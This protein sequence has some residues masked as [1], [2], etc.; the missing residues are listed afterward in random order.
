MSAA[1]RWN[2][3]AYADLDAERAILLRE[4]GE[5]DEQ[6]ADREISA[7]QHARLSDEATNHLARVLV[8][9]R[10]TQTARPRPP[11]RSTRNVSAIIVTVV[12]AAVGIG[13]F[14]T[15]HLAPRQDTRKDTAAT[16]A[17]RDQRLAALVAQQPDDI[18]TRLSYARLLIGEQDYTGALQQFDAVV[19]LDQSNAEAL[20]YGGWL[21][22][23]TGANDGLDRLDRAVQVAPDYPDAHA[24]RG[25]A[26]MRSGDQSTAT[27]ELRRYLELDP[28]GPLSAQ[29]RELVTR[30]STTP[31]PP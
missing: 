29:V 17:E 31:A 2:P 5:L 20:A 18:G 16:P 13:W 21:A 6:L 25:L 10:R 11:R 28:D 23:L 19:K 30:L 24:L 1:A 12:A 15:G 26:L 4:L 9:M 14:L 8:A 3:D 22:V 7:A 27:D